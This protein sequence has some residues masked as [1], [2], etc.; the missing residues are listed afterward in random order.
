[1]LG[2]KMILIQKGRRRPVEPLEILDDGSLLVRNQIGEKET[3]YFGE[4]QEQAE[5][6][7]KG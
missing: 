2:R 6:K 1:M 3:V 7:E 4:L 5:E